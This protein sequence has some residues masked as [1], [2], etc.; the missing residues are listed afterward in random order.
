MECLP[1]V[2]GDVHANLLVLVAAQPLPEALNVHMGHRSGT[3]AWRDERVVLLLLVRE[4]DSAHGPC[5]LGYITLV[6]ISI[7]IAWLTFVILHH[8]CIQKIGTLPL[9]DRRLVILVLVIGAAKSASAW[10]ALGICIFY[11]KA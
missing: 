10:N 3:L 2:R 7:L 9:L 1:G 8:F 4:A 6:C 11:K 5:A